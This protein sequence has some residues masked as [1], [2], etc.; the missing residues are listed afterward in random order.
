MNKEMNTNLEERVQDIEKK[1]EEMNG[2][3]KNL[4]LKYQEIKLE[5]N[6]L[7][8]ELENYRKK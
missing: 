1:N 7:I 5:N 3:N 4:S 8:E 2:N 6:T